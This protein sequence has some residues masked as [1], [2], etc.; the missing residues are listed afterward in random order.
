[1]K[2]HFYSPT[3]AS[4]SKIQLPNDAVREKIIRLNETVNEIK[5]NQIH[6]EKHFEQLEKVSSKH[7]NTLQNH[8]KALRKAF[9]TL[10]DIVTEEIDAVKDEVYRE[11]QESNS[12]LN[13]KVEDL[14][15]V[16]RNNQAEEH[17]KRVRQF[18]A[19]QELRDKV[20][21]LE[22]KLEDQGQFFQNMIEGTRDDSKVIFEK[23][24]VVVNDHSA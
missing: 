4:T 9:N 15:K 16:V 23:L 12:V 19:D 2:K 6:E 21:L 17:E 20:K 7:Y 18:A 11:L 8:I 3:A 10:T 24:K 5:L 14:T 1:M 13:R 22:K